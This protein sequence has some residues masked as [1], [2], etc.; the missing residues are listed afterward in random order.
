MSKA[1]LEARVCELEALLVRVR[2]ERFHE[3]DSDFYE[4]C[5]GCGRSPYN[6]PR[7]KDGCLV[8]AIANALRTKP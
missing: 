8:P 6:Q 1:E 4:H 2:E 3:P 5:A 7:H